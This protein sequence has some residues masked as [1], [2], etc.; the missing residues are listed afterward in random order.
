M[1]SYYC[2]VARTN[3]DTTS[4]QSITSKLPFYLC[5]HHGDAVATLRTPPRPLLLNIRDGMIQDQAHGIRIFFAMPGKEG[6][7]TGDKKVGE[8]AD[9]PY[10]GFLSVQTITT[11]VVLFRVEKMLDDLGCN[12]DGGVKKK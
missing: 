7:M 2:I 6:R 1:L 9:G 12:F 8:D 5:E 4:T 10:I 3:T 11:I